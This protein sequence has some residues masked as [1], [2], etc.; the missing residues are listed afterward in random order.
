MT[1]SPS[2]RQNEP[3]APQPLD[4]SSTAAS[5]DSPKQGYLGFILEEWPWGQRISY[6]VS[7]A[8]PLR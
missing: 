7:L 3:S 5:S 2:P 6:G 4:K 1:A 8:V